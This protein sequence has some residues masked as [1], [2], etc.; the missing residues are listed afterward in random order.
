MKLFS[1]YQSAEAVSTLT[2]AIES[3]QNDRTIKEDERKECLENLNKMRKA[4][5]KRKEIIII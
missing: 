5:K 4:F 1:R 2:T 3:V